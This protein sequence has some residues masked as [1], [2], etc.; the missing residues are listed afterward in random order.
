M[1]DLEKLNQRLA[2][3]KSQHKDFDD[4]IAKLDESRS[5]YLLQI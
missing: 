5:Y 2:K 1:D 4:V 3:L